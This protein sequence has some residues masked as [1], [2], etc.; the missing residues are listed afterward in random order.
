MLRSSALLNGAA[1]PYQYVE[2]IEVDSLDDFRG[3]VRTDAM[4]AVAREFRGFADAPMFIVT[5]PL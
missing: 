2:V 3:E 1:A 4:R 5:D